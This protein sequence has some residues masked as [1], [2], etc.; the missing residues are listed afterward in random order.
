MHLPPLTGFDNAINLGVVEI[1]EEGGIQ[2]DLDE[3]DLIHLP[4]HCVS[5]QALLS[6]A[7]LGADVALLLSTSPNYDK[8][9]RGN[10]KL[11]EMR[12]LAS[13]VPISRKRRWLPRLPKPGWWSVGTARRPPPG[14]EGRIF[15]LTFGESGPY[16]AIRYTP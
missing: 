5:F 8:L 7:C 9:Y 2:E 6:M 15:S 1:L 11:F 3:L 13:T 4:G 12:R 14:V 10:V 16:L